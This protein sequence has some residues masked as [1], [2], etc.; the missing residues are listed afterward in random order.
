MVGPL[1]SH[2]DRLGVQGD[3]PAPNRIQ[4]LFEKGQ[5]FQRSTLLQPFPPQIGLDR[6]QAGPMRP[7]GDIEERL[8]FVHDVEGKDPVQNLFLLVGALFEE[9]AI[10]VL[11]EHTR[12]QEH[13]DG[14]D[15]CLDPLPHGVDALEDQGPRVGPFEDDGLE[16]E[17]AAVLAAFKDSFERIGGAL[18][19][20]EEE[21]SGGALVKT[22]PAIVQNR[23]RMG[24]ISGRKAF[25]KEG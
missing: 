1:A 12:G 16:V 6:R 20:E 25:S 22:C 3:S 7:I 4:V 9:V 10:A 21:G 11:G 8:E 17:K 15:I 18:E 13:V 24:R 2:D 19:G 14:T 5:F 23:R